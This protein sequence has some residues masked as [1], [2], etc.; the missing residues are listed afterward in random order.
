MK[1]VHREFKPVLST[2]KEKKSRNVEK[3]FETI[4]KMKKE[5]SKYL[6]RDL[7]WAENLE[8]AA[9]YQELQQN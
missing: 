7:S 9:E 8:I 6:K 3:Y 5:R 4:L 2:I 1:K